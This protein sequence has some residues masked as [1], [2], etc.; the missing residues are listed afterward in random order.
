MEVK[1]HP[2]KLWYIQL[3]LYSR[4]SIG[5]LCLPAMVEGGANSGQSVGWKG[6]GDK[7]NTAIQFRGRD[8][9]PGVSVLSSCLKEQA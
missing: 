1:V 9:V 4:I 7:V 8:Y 2:P 6:G 3:Q 5:V